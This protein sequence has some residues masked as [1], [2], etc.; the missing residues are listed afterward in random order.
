MLLHIDQTSTMGRLKSS[1]LKHCF[2]LRRLM[3]ISRYMSIYE[4]DL[5]VY[6]VSFI[7]RSTVYMQSTKSLN[8]ELLTEAETS[9]IQGNGK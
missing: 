8:S 3:L 7:C 1:L 6:V 2:V 4:A 5:R 9:S